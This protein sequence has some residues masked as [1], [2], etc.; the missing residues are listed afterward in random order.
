M[1]VLAFDSGMFFGWAAAGAGRKI[2]SGSVR[3]RGSPLEMGT[4]GNHCKEIV[5]AKIS[6]E[7]PDLIAFATPFIG[8]V[9]PKAFIARGGKLIQPSFQAIAPDNIRPL[10]GCLTVIEMTADDMGIRCQEFE[11]SEARVALL[12]KG[13]TPR[14]SKDIKAAVMSACARW[15]PRDNHAAD[16]ICIAIHAWEHNNKTEAHRTTPLFG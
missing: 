5:L 16:A 10:F 11:E 2:T 6:D 4:T 8:M 15:N 9:R 1:R 12:G 13:N 3:L 7:Q 14:K